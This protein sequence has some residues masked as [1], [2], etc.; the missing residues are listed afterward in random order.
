M[1][2]IIHLC[3]WSIHGRGCA[4]IHF[5][6]SFRDLTLIGSY[7]Y[8]LQR[9]FLV[10]IRHVLNISSLLNVVVLCVV[11][12][13]NSSHVFR[14][15]WTII[16]KTSQQ[17]CAVAEQD[18]AEMD[19]TSRQDTVECVCIR[20]SSTQYLVLRAPH[21]FSMRCSQDQDIVYILEATQRSS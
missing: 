14:Q 4:T 11:S 8:H 16:K 15:H 5:S 19:V 9:R 2:D 18:S 7:G 17:P 6:G 3:Q 12:Q 13:E 1:A 20:S 21:R 10:I